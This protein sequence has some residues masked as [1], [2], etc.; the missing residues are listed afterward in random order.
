MKLKEFALITGLSLSLIASSCSLFRGRK[1]GEDP[2]TIMGVT[3]QQYEAMIKWKS[4]REVYYKNID[5]DSE[6][7]KIIIKSSPLKNAGKGKIPDY[8]NRVEIYIKRGVFER[9]STLEGTIEQ[10]VGEGRY[11]LRRIL[12]WIG[13]PVKEE[14]VV[15]KDNGLI[16]QGREIVYNRFNDNFYFKK[17]LESIRKRGG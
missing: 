1:T 6:L 5:F 14:D 16:V 15:F 10:I 3:K 7:E 12:V 11:T 2:W 17:D 8:S 9:K 4:F 13:K